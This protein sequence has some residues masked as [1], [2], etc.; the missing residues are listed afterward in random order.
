MRY[1]VISDIHGNLEAF[2][3]VLSAISE[4][5]VDDYLFLGD[6]IGYGADPKE[7]LRLLK[8]LNP[9]AA[10]AGNHE[11]GVLGKLDVSYFNDTARD[12]IAWAAKVLDG[13]DREY[14]ESF[15]LVYQDEKVTL[16]HGTL[17]MPEEFYYIFDNEDAYV[18]LSQMNN[19]LCFVGHSHVPGIFSFDH[20]KVECMDRTDIKMDGENRYLVNVGSVGQPRDGD[21]KASFAVYD[22]EELTVEIKRA[23][24]D[25]K[26]A[27]RKILNAGL[28]AKLAERLSE[29]R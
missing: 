2:E 15:P 26:K 10:I 28:P 20:N 29:G 4:E 27:Q 7:C 12:A 13:A 11:W 5:R 24:Y 23:E 14:I 9:V 6:A 1:A 16:V 3:S 25:V 17:N 22:D 21:P 18:T 19:S 8:S